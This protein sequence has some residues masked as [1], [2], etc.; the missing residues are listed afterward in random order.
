[1]P[2]ICA[3]AVLLDEQVTLISLLSLTISC[4]TTTS[5]SLSTAT[6]V[7]HRTAAVIEMHV[8]GSTVL[9]VKQFAADFGMQI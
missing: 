1:V 8:A 5:S 7:Q 4:C 2:L 6:H 3:D 9:R